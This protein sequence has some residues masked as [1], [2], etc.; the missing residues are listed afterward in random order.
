MVT[1]APHAATTE[2]A[3]VVRVAARAWERDRYLAALLAA[4]SVRADLIALAAFAGE[5]ARIPGYVS[6]PMLG[7]IRLQWWRDALDRMVAGEGGPANTIGHPIADALGAVI[8]RHG[9]PIGL[10]HGLVDAHAA[11]LVD[12]PFADEAALRANLAASEGALF[13]LAARVLGAQPADLPPDLMAAAAHSYGLAR[14]L[15][16]L[17]AT[18]AEHRCLLPVDKLAGHG[19]SI[20]QLRQGE[21]LAGLGRV[22]GEVAA[23]AATEVAGIEGGWRALPRSVRAALLPVALVRPY[24]RA[25]EGWASCSLATRIGIKTGGANAAAWDRVEDIAPLTRVWRLWMAHRL[26]L[27]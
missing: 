18:L 14:L 12:T 13:E 6:E 17:P 24:L 9:L 7:E 20:D 10:L 1:P 22:V 25:C 2:P 27:R 23:G 16:E 3:D 8:A 26:G 11:R 5:V 15:I 4:A 21:G 19:V